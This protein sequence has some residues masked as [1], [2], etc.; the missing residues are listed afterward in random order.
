MAIKELTE[1]I[2]DNSTLVRAPEVFH[3]EICWIQ[4]MDIA[5]LEEYIDAERIGRSGTRIT[6]E[7][8]KYFFDVYERYLAI[9]EKHDYKYDWDDLAHTVKA[10][11][12]DD[13]DEKMY[14]HIYA[15]PV[16]AA[17]GII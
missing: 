15:Q 6:R 11:L 2:G 5:T 16:G 17:T 8:R 13:K 3:E 12:K 10:E 9:R 14:K 7:K 1:E 4:K